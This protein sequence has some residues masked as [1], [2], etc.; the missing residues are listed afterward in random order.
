MTVVDLRLYRDPA[1]TPVMV[2][3]DTQLE[4]VAPNRALGLAGA[5]RA[6]DNCK[7]L[8]KFAR[9]A[10]YPVA[11]TRWQQ[12]G[13][14]FGKSAHESGWISGLSPTGADMIFD[15]SLPSCYANQQFTEMMDQGGGA[16]AVIAGFTGTIACLSTIIDAY[17]R[18]HSVTFV[19]DASASHALPRLSQERAHDA[20]AQIIG[21]YGPVM[22]TAQWIGERSASPNS[23]AGAV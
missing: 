5:T 9:S 19:A 7:V 12:N 16:N 2:F 18:R 11:F 3:I 8:L 13:K 14:F 10:G 23:Q 20:V 4:Y 17:Q 1:Y 22:T 15:R 6:V 21:L